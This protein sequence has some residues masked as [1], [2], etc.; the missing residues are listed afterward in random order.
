MGMAILLILSSCDKGME[1][2]H[3]SSMTGEP[4]KIQLADGEAD[5]PRFELKRLIAE[6]QESQSDKRL[7][8]LTRLWIAAA[9]MNGPVEALTALETLQSDPNPE[10]ARMAQ[11]ALSDLRGLN[12]IQVNAVPEKAATQLDPFIGKEERVTPYG[13]KTVEGNDGFDNPPPVDPRIEAQLERLA[14]RIRHDRDDSVRGEALRT[15]SMYRNRSAVD[16][17]LEGAED[18][19]TSNRLTAIRHL[20][21]SAGDNLDIDGRIM[22]TLRKALRDPERQVA[23]LARLAIDDLES[24]ERRRDETRWIAWNQATS[25]SAEADI[26]L[27]EENAPQI[28][29]TQ[30][31]VDWDEHRIQSVFEPNHEARAAGIRTLSLFR[32]EASVDIL[33]EV[34]AHDTEANNRLQAVKTMWYSAADGLN[35]NERITYA[36]RDALSDH[37]P[38]V[39]E[40]ARQALDD[41]DR[42]DQHREQVLS[43]AYTSR[44]YEVDPVYRREGLNGRY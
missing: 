14:A 18:P 44:V 35:T 28:S 12:N 39:V 36:L 3:Q 43:A 11:E 16:I 13:M 8:T 4:A 6:L 26:R 27:T 37:D 29:D 31:D 33:M 41:L 19:T 22:E 20:W 42:L 1:T 40:L 23:N 10:V 15:A 32:N 5:D 2:P 25:E 9:D 21:Y 24:L 7:H 34:A 17:L 30:P 38:R